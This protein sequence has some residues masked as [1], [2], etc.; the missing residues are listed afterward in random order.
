MRELRTII[1]TSFFVGSYLVLFLHWM[2]SVIKP[3]PS[4]HQWLSTEQAAEEAY[5]Q[6]LV[7]GRRETCL[8]SFNS[9]RMLGYNEA[10]ARWCKNLEG[11]LL[12]PLFDPISGGCQCVS[13]I[14]AHQR[15]HQAGLT[16]V[17][18]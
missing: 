10:C 11:E 2:L 14:E 1:G 4:I 3:P 5:T 17:V 16:H 6:G 7:D 18:F 13:S 12:V 15:G 9:G 8:E